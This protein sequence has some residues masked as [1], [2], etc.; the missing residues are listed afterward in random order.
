[1]AKAPKL[2]HNP[3]VITANHLASGDVVYLARD[4]AWTRDISEAA[5]APD[6]AA[7]AVLLNQAEQAAARNEI[8]GPYAIPVDPAHAPPRPVQFRERIRA[9]GPTAGNNLSSKS[10]EAQNVSV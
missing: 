1:M 8:V 4:A 2:I 7:S 9:R 10:A 3:Q 5:I 6:L